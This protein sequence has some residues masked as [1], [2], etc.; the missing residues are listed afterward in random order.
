MAA[1]QSVV[2]I[3]NKIHRKF[4]LP[5]TLLDIRKHFGTNNI[6]LID[7]EH[8]LEIDDDKYQLQYGV[9]YYVFNKSIDAIMQL[10]RMMGRDDVVGRLAPLL[11]SP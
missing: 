1:R 4:Q 8:E 5:M 10:A 7:E 6:A 2:V 11:G 9:T 3:H